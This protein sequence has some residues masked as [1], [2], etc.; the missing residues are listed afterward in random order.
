[1]S[2]PRPL[3]GWNHSLKMTLKDAEAMEVDPRWVNCA[4]SFFIK[5]IGEV[6]VYI[7]QFFHSRWVVRVQES[8]LNKKEGSEQFNF[9]HKNDI[10]DFQFARF[11]TFV[12]PF[13]FG[14]KE[15]ALVAF[16]EYENQNKHV[17]WTKRAD[18][19]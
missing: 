18:D 12:F 16:I 17:H 14:S 4:T 19:I 7:E 9:D 11:S 3:L 13:T 15:E 10:R 5:N 2:N 6:S 8:Y 1:M